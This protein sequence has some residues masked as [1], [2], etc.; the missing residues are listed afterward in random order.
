[1]KGHTRA[2]TTAFTLI[3]LLVVVAIIALLISIL[4]P[5]LSRARDQTKAV[6]CLAN[7]RTLGQG[8][9]SYAAGD[10]DRLPGGLHPALNRNQGLK[11]L[12]E[13]PVHPMSLGNA[14]E[15]QNRQLLWL[16]RSVFS[17]S[18]EY[19][20]SVTDQ[21]G[22]CP[23]LASI[24]PDQ[25]FARAAPIN[26]GYYVYPTHYVVNNVGALDEQGGPNDNVRP[27]NPQYYFG[28]SAPLGTSDDV[29]RLY[30]AK[31]PRRRWSGVK[32]SAEE[33]MIA[34]AWYRRAN[35]PFAAELQQEG[36]YQWDWSGPALPNFAPHFA[37][38]RSYMLTSLDQREAECSQISSGRM[39]GRTNTVFFDGHAAPVASKRLVFEDWTLLYG[40]PGTVNPLRDNPPANDPIWG[41]YWE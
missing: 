32:R 33:W 21:V 12:M 40:F 35:F 1:M 20:N 10:E 26:H 23:A 5:A 29:K 39:D 14:I 9:I 3:E 36:P 34:D 18:T 8:V 24:N 38:L 28:Y 19:A 6:K 17:D 15:Y 27:T 41:A 13:D 25:N 31:Y 16:L 4:L 37:K 11:A 22:T 2:G 30:E 7:L